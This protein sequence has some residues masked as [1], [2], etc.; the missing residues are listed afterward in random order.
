MASGT[1]WS[2]RDA[3]VS[4]A[5]VDYPYAE[6]SIDIN[7]NEIDFTNF[8][9]SGEW[10]EFEVG[11]K[12]GTITCTGPLD[13]DLDLT[14]LVDTQVTVI[15]QFGTGCSISWPCRAMKGNLKSAVTDG[16]RTSDT[17]KIIGAP[18]PTFGT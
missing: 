7:K 11:F 9:S 10:K 18:T 14:I 15:T 1:F 16:A 2:G 3:N 13:T 6:F 8:L 4:Y 12:D 5:G 17:F